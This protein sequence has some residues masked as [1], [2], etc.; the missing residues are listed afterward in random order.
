MM[1]LT[2]SFIGSGEIPVNKSGHLMML[3]KLLDYEDRCFTFF[4]EP[5]VLAR[6]GLNG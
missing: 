2:S 6:K 5:K 4:E 1:G 3:E